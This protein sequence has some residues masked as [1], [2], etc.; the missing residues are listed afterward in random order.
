[1][2][3]LPNLLVIGAMKCGTTALHRYLGEHPQISMAEAKE[4]NFFGGPDVASGDAD[5]RPTGLAQGPDGS[6][7]VTDDAG[8]R[9]WKIVYTGGT[10]GN[11]E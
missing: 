3:A 10:A 7:Y 2:A 6:L 9:I 8:G 1:M 4:V 11:R 5:H